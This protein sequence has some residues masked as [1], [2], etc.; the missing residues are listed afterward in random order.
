MA[1]KKK[2][3]KISS[4]DDSSASFPLSFLPSDP[5]ATLI[6]LTHIIPALVTTTETCKIVC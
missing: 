3:N 4:V 5:I 2:K 6:I 1:S